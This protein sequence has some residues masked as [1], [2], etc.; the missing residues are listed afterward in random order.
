MSMNFQINDPTDVM[1]ICVLASGS[2]GNCAVVRT[3]RGVM[4]ID[5]GIGPRTTA[6]RLKGT[7]VS[8]ADVS[9]ICLTHLD[10]DHF[11]ATWAPPIVERGIRVF[12]HAERIYDLFGIVRQAIPGPAAADLHKAFFPLIEPFDEVFEPLPE[13]LASAVPLSHDAEGSHG[14]VLAAGGAR[15]GYA[16][17]LG[18]VPAR[19]VD[20]FD[21]LDVLAIEC[22]YDPQMQRASGRPLL[23]QR[24]ITGGRGHLSNQQAFDAVGAMFER[25]R[26]RRQAL[27][28]HVV[29]L[30]RSRQCNCPKLVRQLFTRDPRIAPRLTLAEQFHRTEWLGL[31]ERTPVPGEQ[32]LLGLG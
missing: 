22:N 11:R 31:T 12:C 9:A 25:C 30:H 26:Q 8:L 24:R 21:A 5:A 13:V 15:I 4:L 16:T 18:N 28:A 1:E 27:P 10:G 23:L 19:L 6:A 17:D 20:A 29:L 3:P 32:L 2:G 7:G 14:F